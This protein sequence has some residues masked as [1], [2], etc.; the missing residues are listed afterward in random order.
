[1]GH[2]R[3]R[4]GLMAGKKNRLI[5]FD[6]AG[7]HGTAWGAFNAGLTT[8]TATTV[9]HFTTPHGGAIIGTAVGGAVLFNLVR[10]AFSRKR[11]PGST[12]L[13]RLGCW[14]GAGTWGMWMLDNPDWS[15]RSWAEGVLYLAGA[16]TGAGVIV[17]LAT[18]P[19]DDEEDD[20][21]VLPSDPGEAKRVT[22][23]LDWEARIERVC[24][25][26]VEFHGLDEWEKGNG[27][28]LA[29]RL[30]E[31]GV[32]LDRLRG[33]AANLASDIDLPP[34]CAI[35]IYA[36]VGPDA[37][38]RDFLMDVPTENALAD[39][40]KYP[41]DVTRF[42]INDPVPFG[43]QPNSDLET[44]EM[45]SK[46]LL[47]VGETGSG[48]TNLGHG[49][50]GGFVRA[51]DTLVMQIDL[52]GAGLSRPWI[53][54][55]LEGRAGR[56]AVNTVADTPQ[57]A[58]QL[59]RALLRVGHARKA[60]YQ[61]LM[62]QVDDDKLPIGHLLPDGNI[63]SE[64]ILMVDEIAKITGTRSEWPDLRDL[65]V[66]VINELRASG[67]RVVLLG[68]RATDDVVASSIQ[69]M[70]AIKIGM[71]MTSK[72]EMSYLF[73]WSEGIA[74]EDAPYPG[75][76]FIQHDSAT[77]PRPFRAWRLTPSVIDRIA[78]AADAWIPE[79]DPISRAAA[80]G[81]TIDG[82]PLKGVPDEDLDWYERRWAGWERTNRP[83]EVEMAQPAIPPVPPMPAREG[84]VATVDDV[85]Q[86]AQ[87]GDAALSARI[88]ESQGMTVGQSEQVK[89]DFARVL[90]EAGF[91]PEEEDW[92]DPAVW[93]RP[94]EGATVPVS[95][96]EQALML[97]I[98]GNAGPQG[99]KPKELREKLTEQ[100]KPMSR[101]KLHQMLKAAKEAGDAFQPQYGKWARGVKP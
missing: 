2:V 101:D 10:A 45:R 87:E 56:P 51:V 67:V 55:W 22:I 75:C 97:S 88:A 16:A 36:K 58:M 15:F 60:G 94:P 99:M 37:G 76:G 41:Q 85:L 20:K 59:L 68:L 24:G 3:E 32:L 49:L 50:T 86:A 31:G 35:N 65:I 6:F 43:V 78:V 62:A 29:G 71:K 19:K 84:S 8:V 33:Q 54:P 21:P 70:C 7:P 57:K 66:Q 52:T 12:V 100:G 38:R 11:I 28:T 79:L 46:C 30:P 64:V 92:N 14:A 18:E 72:S 5:E 98:L 89:D 53:K 93:S 69:A 40:Q 91:D 80:N 34:G 47:A 77:K 25:I 9:A 13:Y 27:Y 63:L 4:A 61:D 83:R 74:P 1:M 26:K 48:K 17:G 23:A 96:D 73:G 95:E 82:T 42:T 90:R 44:V 81:R 39:D